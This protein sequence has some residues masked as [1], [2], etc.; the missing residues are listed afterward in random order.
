MLTEA[1]FTAEFNLLRK[2]NFWSQ[3]DNN[4]L[5]IILS[6]MLS[7]SSSGG[8][9]SL[10]VS[11]SIN[12]NLTAGAN[13]ITHNLGLAA[14]FYTMVSVRNSVTGVEILLSVTGETANSCIL[15]MATA[16]SNVNIKIC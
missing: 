6:N 3:F 14:P 1:Q 4:Q 13:L 15:N 8:A 2:Q 9:T 11:Y 12:Q 7:I 5:K 10:I 16:A